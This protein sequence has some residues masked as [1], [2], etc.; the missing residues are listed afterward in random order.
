[1]DERVRI[2]VMLDR[3][4]SQAEV[5]RELGVHRLT[6]CREN[7]RRSWSPESVAAVYTPYRPEWLNT[8]P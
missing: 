4:C 1:M 8:G 3:G 5:A 6:V 2:E 7:R